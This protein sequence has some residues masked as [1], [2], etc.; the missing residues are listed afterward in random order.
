MEWGTG[1]A[2]L[3]AKFTIPL[4][5]NMLNVVISSTDYLDTNVIVVAA[6]ILSNTQIAVGAGLSGSSVHWNA[7]AFYIIIGI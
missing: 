1:T 6:Q 7:A 2:V 3:G 5:C 4:A